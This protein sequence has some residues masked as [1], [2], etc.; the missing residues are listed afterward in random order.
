V[1]E[2][3]A[4]EA[5]ASPEDRIRAFW[6]PV[7][8]R[9][10]EDL[11]SA[12]ARWAE[13]VAKNSNPAGLPMLTGEHL[14]ECFDVQA[15]WSL[16][17]VWNDDRISNFYEPYLQDALKAVL[18]DGEHL[19]ANW[20]PP[21]PDRDRFLSALRLNL[22]ARVLH[23][24][25]EALKRVRN[26][27]SPA[28]ADG[29]AKGPLRATSWADIEISFVSDERVQIHNG[30]DTETR[31]YDELGFADR[32]NGK[33]NQAWVTLRAMAEE[34]GIIRDGAKTGASWDR[35]QY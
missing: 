30:T 3:K 34:R 6:E 25:A 32:R 15:Y 19:S 2:Q 28:T 16:S 11:A 26:M 12:R 21:I 4:S 9:I 5:Q 18:K 14:V 13:K 7:V 27:D 10:R 24:K 22:Q 33:P 35:R 31:N 29:A 8:R 1:E 17:T 20:R 23:W